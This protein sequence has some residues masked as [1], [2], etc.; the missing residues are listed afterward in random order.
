MNS[1]TLGLTEWE[2]AWLR[3][4]QHDDPIAAELVRIYETV[5]NNL[6]DTEARELFQQKLTEWRETRKPPKRR[7]RR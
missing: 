6:H 3:A 7:G 4:N 2:I 1:K 5:R